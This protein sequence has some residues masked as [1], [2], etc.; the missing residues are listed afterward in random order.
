MIEISPCKQVSSRYFFGIIQYDSHK[1][2]SFTRLF[3][4][5][6]IPSFQNFVQT[7]FFSQMRYND[8]TV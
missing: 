5:K 4:W 6:I 1:I 7:Y 2:T 3:Y 8:H